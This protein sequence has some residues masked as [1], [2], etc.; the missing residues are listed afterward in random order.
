MEPQTKPSEADRAF[1]EWVDRAFEVI[2][3]TLAK[4]AATLGFAAV[5]TTA[6]GRPF[7]SRNVRWH[8]GAEMLNLC[9]EG[10]DHYLALGYSRNRHLQSPIS[11]GYYV[12]EVSSNLQIMMVCFPQQRW[13]NSLMQSSTSR[14]NH[15]PN[16]AVNTDAHRRRCAPWWSPVTLVR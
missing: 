12:Y 10:R 1:Y 14:R 9:Q 3:R 16:H 11:A 8:R 5:P 6:R 13:L 2:E 15:R 4:R 7:G